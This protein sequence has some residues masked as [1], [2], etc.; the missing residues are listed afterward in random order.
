MSVFSSHSL[1]TMQEKLS[2]IKNTNY[3]DVNISIR[4][5]D[6]EFNKERVEEFFLTLSYCNEI[7]NK[8]DMDLRD[9]LFDNSHIKKLSDFLLNHRNINHLSLWLPSNQVSDKG[10]SI[11]FKAISELKN[12]VILNVN[13][14]WNFELTNECVKDLAEGLKGLQDLKEVRVNMSVKT[15][16]DEKGEDLFKNSL[17][18]HKNL[19][20]A[21]FN[22]KNCF[23]YV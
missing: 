17:T 5:S 12:L 7:T 9:N 10:A 6:R 15:F 8:I 23:V 4:W 21:F 22:D 11:L 13:L 18:D 19:A 14:E 16:V 2:D 1:K 3:E 20:K